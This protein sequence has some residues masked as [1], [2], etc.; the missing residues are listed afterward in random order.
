VGLGIG[1]AVM[2][3]RTGAMSNQ[4]TVLQHQLSAS[5]AGVTESVAAVQAQLASA[6]ASLTALTQQNAALQAEV[7]AN[8]DQSSSSTDSS[9]TTAPALVITSRTVT[10]STVAT[11]GTITMTAKV[12]G[13]PTSVTMRVYT[14]TKSYDKTFS[15]KKT[16]TS[17]DTQ[18][19]S[20]KVSAPTK[21][22]TYHFYATANKGSVHV[23]MTGASPGTIKVK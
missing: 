14:T 4:I 12:T 17:G 10:P 20:L 9:T 21:V 23:T 15:L 18:T 1:L 19:W 2:L 5:S 11:S 7:T 3:V 13:Q 8:A 22:G 6:E 16:S